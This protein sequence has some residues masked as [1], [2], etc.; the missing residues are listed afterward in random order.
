MNE[1][2]IQMFSPF[3]PQLADRIDSINEVAGFFK[4]KF[5]S[6]MIRLV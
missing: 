5:S 4:V 6:P 1:Y 2:G 3:M